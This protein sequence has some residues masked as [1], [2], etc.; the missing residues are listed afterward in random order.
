MRPPALVVDRGVCAGE[1][2]AAAAA[3]VGDDLGGDGERGLLGGACSEVEAD[4]RVQPGQFEFGDADRAQ[5]VVAFQMG[6]ARTHRSDVRDRELQRHFQQRNIE[7]GVMGEHAEHGARVDGRRRE[8]AVR[9]VD[10]DLVGVGEAGR[11]GEDGAGVAHGDVV[12][13]ECRRP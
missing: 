11:C 6:A 10:D 3:P 7:L 9:P 2:Y 13:E 4:R 5:P 8:V 12:A 1:R